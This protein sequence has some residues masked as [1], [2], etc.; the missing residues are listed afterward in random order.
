MIEKNE[1][2]QQYRGY[3]R[4]IEYQ[5]FL[6]IDEND[7][8]LSDY[9]FEGEEF[10][11]DN[12]LKVA[13]KYPQAEYITFHARLMGDSDFGIEDELSP[14]DDLAMVFDRDKLKSKNMYGNGGGVFNHKDNTLNFKNGINYIEAEPITKEDKKKYID[15]LNEF[16][17]NNQLYFV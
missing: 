16:F 12:L 2:K 15:Y 8:W 5:G 10:D 1:M 4:D 17:N 7:N 14:I 6:A 3:V 11:R 9:E 13:K